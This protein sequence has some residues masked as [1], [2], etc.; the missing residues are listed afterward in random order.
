MLKIKGN[1]KAER[2]FRKLGLGLVIA[3]SAISF[4]AYAVPYYWVDWQ[5]WN[6]AGGT[7]T[8]V[9]TPSSGPDVNVSFAAITSTGGA[10]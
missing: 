5:T 1:I 7:A 10:G 4:S 6:P 9:I 2:L 8:G 3:S